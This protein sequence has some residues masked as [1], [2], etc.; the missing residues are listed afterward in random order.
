VPQGPPYSGKKEEVKLEAPKGVT[1]ERGS[2]L[3][4]AS[5]KG[6]KEGLPF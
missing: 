3:P 1:V 4:G 2:G 5:Y 6:G